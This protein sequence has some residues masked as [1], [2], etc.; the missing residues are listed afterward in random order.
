MLGLN[1]GPLGLGAIALTVSPKAGLPRLWQVYMELAV[2]YIC[3]ITP[4]F[5]DPWPRGVF[6]RNPSNMLFCVAFAINVMQAHPTQTHVFW[7][8]AAPASVT[9]MR[10]KPWTWRQMF[11]LFHQK[12]SPVSGSM[13]PIVLYMLRIWI[14]WAGFTAF[15]SKFQPFSPGFDLKVC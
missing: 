8:S 3:C 11:Q 15:G 5:L 2:L 1:P 6:I 10:I 13:K 14:L 4:F 12:A 7:R 9:M